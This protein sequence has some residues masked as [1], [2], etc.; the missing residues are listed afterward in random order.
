MKKKTMLKRLLSLTAAGALCLGIALPAGAAET[1]STIQV[2]QTQGTVSVANSRGRDLSLRDNM[3]LYNGYQV[4]TEKSSYVWL[5]LDDAKLAKQ[6]A[7]SVVEVRKDGKKLELLVSSGSLYFNVTEPLASDETLNIRTSSMVTGVR[8]TC[9]WVESVDSGHSQVYVLEGR[10]ECQVTDPVSGQSKT[11]SIRSGEVGNFYVYTQ[12]Q[13]GEYCGVTT[14]RF[15]EDDINGFVLKELAGDSALCGKI[16]SASGLNVSGAAG[17]AQAVLEA[18]ESAMNRRVDDA[19]Q[20]AANQAGSI[21][22]T[23]VWNGEGGGSVEQPASASAE[24]LSSQLA[25]AGVDKVTVAGSGGAPET[26]TVDKTLDVPAGKTLTLGDNVNI[27]VQ[28]GAKMNVAGTLHAAGDLTNNGTIDVTS[29]NTLRVEGQLVN[30]AG[31]TIDNHGSGRIVASG[32]ILN[33]GTILNRDNARIVS[34]G[35]ATVRQQSGGTLRVTGGAVVND[36]GGY[37]LLQEGSMTPAQAR[38]IL[39]AAGTDAFRSKTGNIFGAVD[40]AGVYTS[41]TPEGYSA[42]LQSDGYYAIGQGGTSPS[43]PQ[44]GGGGGGTVY[45]PSTY[46]LTFDPNG[47]TLAAGAGAPVREGYTFNGWADSA[48][49]PFGAGAAV[50]SNMTLYAQWIQNSGGGQTPYTITYDPNGGTLS[51]QGATPVWADHTFLGWS[52]ARD[53]SAAYPT[54]VSSD[55]TLYAQ[56]QENGGNIP[57]PSSYAILFELNGGTAG[58]GGVP[59]KAGCIFAGWYTDSALTQGLESLA[60]VAKDTTLYAKWETLPDTGDFVVTG[61]VYGTDYSYSSGLLTIKTAT[62]LTI[63]NKDTNTA[64]TDHIEIA[65]GVSANVILAGVKIDTSSTDKPAFVIEGNSSLTIVSVTLLAGQE[66]QLKSGAGC[67]GLQKSNTSARLVINGTYSSLLEAEG[68]DGGAGIGGGRNGVG[69]FI[70]INGGRITATGGSQAAG[71]GGGAGG[72]SYEITINDS[73]VG[74]SPSDCTVTAYGCGG[75]A[76]IGGG[77]NSSGSGII[78]HDGTVKAYSNDDG[79]A[80]IGGGFNGY[81]SA[82]SIHGGDVYACGNGGAGIGGG[83]R[84]SRAESDEGWGYDIYIYAGIVEA[85]SGN[86]GAGIG[87]GNGGM[88]T[89]IYIYG[90]IITATGSSNGGAGIGGG[91]GGGS[92]ESITISGGKI[93]AIG[94]SQAAGIGGGTSG[95]GKDITI[96]GGK[97]TATGGNEAAG[98]GGGALGTGERIIFTGGETTATQGS[99]VSDPVGGGLDGT[100]SDIRHL[101]GTVNGQGPGSSGI[102]AAAI[103]PEALNADQKRTYAVRKA[104]AK[105]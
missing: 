19:R 76:G 70:T 22:R 69:A 92:G 31:S 85:I 24:Q 88:G 55:L 7:A 40:S 15:S 11:A 21:S 66:N 6:D 74:S 79:G 3:R 58:G 8:G 97:I 49:K 39:S 68:G 48:G 65:D 95:T 72:D 90:D 50:S 36:G 77:R 61:G 89:E 45:L 52:P 71:I 63:K 67:A 103:L 33:A 57:Q 17:R 12:A 94:G 96:S 9:G 29:G 5:N 14:E 82:I 75:G 104:R 91:Y 25:Q 62:P 84:S 4:T 2:T 60:T 80:G 47:G 87:G 99:G 59:T 20:Q 98:I 42:R 18:D 10:L 23:P 102:S 44:G 30:A 100:S 35:I 93:T 32:G 26:I 41:V 83:S 34:E 53:G 13:G 51:A 56:W 28:S 73:T 38:S 78:I 64:T 37:A 16:Q 1:A 105:V 46:T 43:R 101:L 86:G 54:T 27:V 81:G